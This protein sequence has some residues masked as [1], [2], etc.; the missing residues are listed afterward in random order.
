[1]PITSD[2]RFW[3]RAARK[4]ARSKIADPEGYTQTLERTRALLRPG[5]TVLELG[6][7]TGTTALRLADAVQS[8]LGTDISSEM[9]AIAE[10]RHAAEP[11]PGLAF[12]AGTAASLC[13]QHMQFDAV[14]GFN[15]LHLVRDLSETL[16]HIHVMLAPGGLFISKTPCVGEMNMLVRTVLIPAMRAVGK[17]PHVL[18]L[19]TKELGERI[20]TAGFDIIATENHAVKGND[21]RPYIVARR[22]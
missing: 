14:L 19:R 20:H 6:C 22:R 15:Y 9:I 18:S 1:M 11:V 4:Y 7:G 3:N 21:I 13:A 10:E 8:W 12:R 2:A 16:R 5:D 17:A